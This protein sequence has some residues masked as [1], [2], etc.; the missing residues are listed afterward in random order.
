MA[1]CH[2]LLHCGEK[3]TAARQRHSWKRKKE[4]DFAI[5]R[6]GMQASFVQS[7][8]YE[9]VVP[10]LAGSY[11]SHTETWRQLVETTPPLPTPSSSPPIP[12]GIGRSSWVQGISRWVL[13]K[14]ER[15]GC[16]ANSSVV[17][18]PPRAVNL[19]RIPWLPGRESVCCPWRQGSLVSTQSPPTCP[20]SSAGEP[21]QCG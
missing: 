19:S 14:R 4:G 21:S 18:P 12:T 5:K 9:M 3:E 20:V 7:A 2:L 1:H 10:W 15:V 8:V 17:V 6:T 13:A 16:I 11:S